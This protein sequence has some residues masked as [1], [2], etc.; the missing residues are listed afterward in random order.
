MTAFFHDLLLVEGGVY[1]LLGSKPITRISLESFT[2]EEKHA[3]YASLSKDEL[4]NAQI[5]DN[6]SLPQ[7]WEKWKKI[8]DRFPFKRYI[9]LEKE[10]E[11]HVKFLYFVNIFQTA[12]KIQE[13]Y[14]AFR[15]VVKVDFNP[16]EVVLEIQD[17]NS[18]FWDAIDGNSLLWGLLLGYG[19]VNS[20]GFF[21]KHEDASPRITN[22]M[23]S[24]KESHRDSEFV[25][26]VEFSPE[27]FDIPPFISF[28][29]HDGTINHYKY[30]QET[31]KKMYERR[32]FL[33]FTLDVLVKR[34][35]S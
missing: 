14:E 30:E 25:G 4:D 32:D 19:K 1:T 8:S 22:F 33:E 11:E 10:S 12:I 16:L 5:I 34:S 21:W 6:Y 35:L 9:L 2:E 18:K 24:L 3:Y 7:N 15:R 26:K 31:I 28:E 20:Y 29:S 17:K 27:N 13:N 23:S